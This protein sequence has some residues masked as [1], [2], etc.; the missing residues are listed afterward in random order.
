MVPVLKDVYPLKAQYMKGEPVEIAI[1]IENFYDYDYSVQ[2]E[3]GIMDLNRTLSLETI[4]LKLPPQAVMTHVLT[5]GPYQTKMGG[6]GVDVLLH[7][8][9]AEPQRLSGSFDVV[10]DWRKS[11]R[12]GFLSDFHPREA[13]DEQ[14]VALLNK[15]HL[16]LVQFY[17]WMYRHDDLVSPEEVFTDLMGRE[18]SLGVV[19]KKIELCHRYGMKAIAYGAVYAASRA[20]YDRHPDWALYYNNGKVID[21]IDI[22]CIMNIAEQSP[23]HRHIIAEYRKAVEQVDFD[24][25]HMDT[26]GYPKTGFS[27]LGGELKPERLDGQF[28][29]LIANTR[30]ELEQVRDDVCLIFNNVGNW[31]VDTVAAAPQDAVYIEVWNPYERYHHI[32]Q[33]IAWAQQHGGGK[34]VILAAY[35]APFRLEPAEQIDRAHVSALLLS[36]VIFSHGANH[37]LLGENGGVLTQGYY[38]DYSVASDAFIREIRNY[39]D[40]MIRYLHV[41]YAP[42]L[43]DVSMT[44]VEGD[45]LEYVFA[46]A[47]MSTYGE[48]GKVWTVVREN[49]AYKLISFINMTNNDEDYWNRGKKRPAPQGPVTVRILM[50][51]EAES[52]FI[53]SPDAGMGAPREVAAVYEDSPR[54]LTLT[55]TIPELHIWDLLVV[56][57][58]EKGALRGQV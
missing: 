45:N 58:G 16:N 44:H 30:R 40:F 36:A 10:A 54:G 20:F 7:G 32:A 53:A 18:L 31:P 9:E 1:E 4:V 15:L 24:G 25:I 6:F 11:L 56:E 57:K 50:D 26:Y 21:F 2:L 13:G 5:T 47:P 35:L 39:Y 33:I 52:V 8:G 42:S 3:I 22:F 19:K 34:P 23:W 27:R 12:Y 28:P 17:D 51:R 55:V 38:A 37:L 43:R 48:A 14:D 41:L 46:G 29:V 49:E